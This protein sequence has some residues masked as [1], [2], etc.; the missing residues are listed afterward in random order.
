MQGQYGQ[1]QRLGGVVTGL[2]RLLLAAVS[3]QPANKGCQ[4]EAQGFV[5]SHQ[6]SLVSLLQAAGTSAARSALRLSDLQVCIQILYL[7]LF[8]E[9]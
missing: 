3:V 2:L 7:A 5:Q 8:I 9:L 1:W 6:R 4:K